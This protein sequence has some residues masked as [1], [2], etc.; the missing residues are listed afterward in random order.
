M[1]T[2]YF[3]NNWIKNIKKENTTWI[4]IHNSLVNN[5]NFDEFHQCNFN[6]IKGD[7]FE[8]I[9]KYIYLYQGYQTFLYNE[10]PHSLKN[11]L[12]LPDYDRGIDLIYSVNNKDWIGVQCKWRG[13]ISRSIPKSYVAEFMVEI[14]KSSLSHGILFTNVKNITPHHD[15]IYNL[16][17]ITRSQLVNFINNDIIDYILTDKIIGKQINTH[18]DK[19]VLRDYQKDAINSLINNNDSRQCCFMA[20]GTGKTL[21]MFEYMD[22]INIVGKKMLIMVPSLDLMDQTYKK[23]VRYNATNKN[24]NIL[25]ICSEMDKTTLTCGEGTDSDNDNI[26]NEF[27]ALDTN[28]I[29]TT[30]I[31]NITKKL[32]SHDIVVFC[33]Y[34]SCKLLRGFTFDICIFDEAHKTV[35]NRTFGYLLKDNNCKIDKRLFF[36]ATPRYHKDIKN[37]KNVIE[38]CISMDD[39]TIY[40][41]ESYNYSFKKAISDKYILDFQIITYIT[42]PQLEDIVTEKNVEKDGLGVDANTVITAI[43]LAQ[44]IKKYGNSDKIL[45]YHNTVNNAL[46]FKKTLNYVFNKFNLTANIFVMSGKTRIN[47]RC[48]IFNEFED[49]DIGII[50]SAKVL[51]EGVNLPCVDTI[52]FVDPRNSTIDV[53]QC[54]GRGLRLYENQKKCTIILPVHYDNISNEHNFSPIIKILTAMNEI[55][56]KIAEYFVVKKKRNNKIIV[57]NMEVVDWIDD[58]NFDVKYSIDDVVNNLGIK[59]MDRTAL[60]WEIKKNLLFEYCDKY[61]M[62]PTN[63][64]IY[65]NQRIGAWLHH[66]KEDINSH[67][68]DIYIKLATNEYVKGSLNKYLKYKEQNKNKFERH[69]WK[70]LLFEYCD[71][72]KSAP[73]REIIYNGAHI[74]EWFKTQKTKI[75]SGNYDIYVELSTNRCV[76]NS[77]DDYLSRNKKLEWEKWKKLLFEYCNKNERV[78][79]QMFTYKNYRIGAWLANQKGKINS[80]NDDIYIKLADNLYVKNSLDNYLNRNK[81]SGQNEWNKQKKLLFEYCDKKKS[82]PVKKTMYKNY[83]IGSWLHAQKKKINSST[84]N[85]YI[86]LATNPHIKNCLDNYLNRDKQLKWNDWKKLLFEYCDKNKSA[87]NQRVVYKN[88]LIGVWLQT[89]KTKINRGNNKVYTILET[90]MYVKNSLDKYLSKK[91]R[92]ND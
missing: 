8:Y 2:K 44:H 14:N 74:G 82:V 51:N 48:E 77:L 32:K 68:H 31:N 84:D 54:V 50:C 23:F 1:I 62:V 64:V 55:D 10:I 52:M 61:E 91:K 11:K 58:V 63:G 79:T 28:K 26:Y 76:K 7:I 29:Y 83:C 57:R 24:A 65:N 6:K 72:N 78:P 49:S 34:Q 41:N 53:T 30:D 39:K 35:N 60:S 9:T 59:V 22:R 66:Q 3:F 38:K 42:P 17:W 88:Q 4:T 92:V 21:I 47:K 69:E 5:I 86:K 85:I 56:D 20:C 45:T 25:C 19:I 36:T 87:P 46:N 89:Q 71:K 15:D 16:K 18:I 81:K 70:N 37:G 33:T 80:K 12:G 43:Q 13:K 90:N 75:N 27:L 73:S 67:N 40:G